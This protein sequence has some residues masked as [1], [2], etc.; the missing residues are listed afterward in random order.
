MTPA[1]EFRSLREGFAL[2]QRRC[3]ALLRVHYQTIKNWESGKSRV[4]H[5]ALFVMRTLKEEKSK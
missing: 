4:P 3:A 2:S 1:E 5:V